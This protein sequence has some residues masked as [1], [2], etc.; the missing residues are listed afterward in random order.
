M[1]STGEFDL[2]Q[3]YFKRPHH[4]QNPDVVL[5]IGDDCALLSCSA[6]NPNETSDETLAISTD[7]LVEGRHFLANADPRL[8]GHKCLAV[9]LS[10][11]AAMG[12]KPIG[13]TLAIAMPEVRSHWL[14][15]FSKGL[16]ELA[17][18][19]GCTLIG[20]DTTAGPLTISITVFG[21]VN[22]QT[23]LRRDKAQVGDDIWVSHELGDARL[24]LGAL[25]HEWALTDEQLALVAPRMHAPT[26][27]IELGQQLL[28]LAHA[29]ID[30]SDGL[31][32]DLSHILKMSGVSAQI[33]IDDLPASS[34]L[35]AQSLEL[36][37]LCTLNGGDDYELCFTAS[38]QQ[39]ESIEAIGEKLHLRLTK[40]GTITSASSELITLKDRDDRVLPQELSQ[41]YLKS[42]DHFK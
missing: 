5:G 41:Q 8:L 23:A 18:Q 32:G 20:G 7:M 4:T 19:Y 25:R 9:N 29:A 38:P 17:D 35:A 31:L 26:P 42:F 21:Q 30:V 3:R 12:A 36:K 13:F 22:R 15:E 24:A 27:R 10:D 28:G 40:I 33:H 2:I 14:E 1:N 6:K 11:L 16:F 39:R 34:T 37:R